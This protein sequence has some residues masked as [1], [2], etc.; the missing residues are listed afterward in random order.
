MSRAFS[1]HATLQ[2]FAG[3]ALRLVYRPIVDV[4]GEAGPGVIYAANHTAVMDGPLLLAA[5]KQPIHVITKFEVFTGIA[6]AILRAGGAVPIYWHGADRAALDHAVEKIRNQ[7]SVALFP[8]GS[9]CTGQYDWIR[10]GIGYLV[11]KTM[12]PVVPVAVL[13]TRH[14]GQSKVYIT[15]PYQQTAIVVGEPIPAGEFLD[16]IASPPT[17]Q[18]LEVISERI[19]LRLLEFT[20]QAE[21]RVGIQLP[22]D[23][24]SQTPE[25]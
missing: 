24:V 1:L 11:A 6:G 3:A 21:Q 10:S 5:I 22:T 14:T 18:E 17:R 12:A 7:E 4:V 8:E 16:G 25:D 19:R 2:N 15:R 20:L 9:R 13:G 23:D